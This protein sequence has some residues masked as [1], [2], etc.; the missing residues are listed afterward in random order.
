MIDIRPVNWNIISSFNFI[1][2]GNFEQ[3]VNN[4]FNHVWDFFD[5][6]NFDSDR[7]DD[8]FN[9]SINFDDCFI[10]LRNSNFNDFDISLNF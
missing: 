10:R 7:W 1:D 3:S 9:N 4:F 5:S 6:F 2:F 8:L